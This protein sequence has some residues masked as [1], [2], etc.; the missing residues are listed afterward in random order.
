MHRVS[1][2]LLFLVGFL[3]LTQSALGQKVIKKSIIHPG[4]SFISIDA[5]NCY[6]VSLV[7]RKGEEMS[8]T[9]Q[10]E[11]EYNPDLLIN[12]KEEGS[13]LLI[14]AGFQP[15]FVIPNDKLSA[16]KVISIALQL[17]LPEMKSV[18]LFG[19]S[20]NVSVF[21]DYRDLRIS[22]NDGQCRMTGVSEFVE[23]TTQSGDIE[24]RDKAADI[25]ASSKFGKVLKN[26]MPPGTHQY[27]LTTITGNITL[28]KTE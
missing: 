8:V 14:S 15:D 25:E 19:T 20:T 2:P 5:N 11:G 12:I 16:H 1:I 22:L 13:T 27:I 23:V 6:S 18:S 4:I 17:T 7:T 24:V 21:G 10:I 9:A 26:G 28:N 3:L